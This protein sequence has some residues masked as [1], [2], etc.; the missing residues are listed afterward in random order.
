MLYQNGNPHGGDIYG[1][2]IRLDFSANIN[3]LGTPPGVMDAMREALLRSE[4]YPDPYCRKAVRAISRH[5]DIPEDCILLGNG[6]AELIYSFCYAVRPKRV[7][8]PAPTF[9]EY[10][11]A[12]RQTGSEVIRH[13]LR[14]DTQFTLDRTFLDS[15]EE[16]SPDTVFLCH[17]NNPTGQLIRQDVLTDILAFCK[18]RQ[19]RLFLD[20]CFLD[21]SGEPDHMKTQLADCPQQ[22]ILKALTKSYALAGIRIGYGLSSD[23]GLLR[24]MSETVQP[25]NVSVVAQ[26]AAV[27]AMGEDAYIAEAVNFIRT[28]REWLTEQLKTLGLAVC[29][30]DVNFILLRAPEGLEQALLKDGIAIRDCSNYPGLCGGWFRTAVRTHPEN[31]ILIRTIEKALREG[32]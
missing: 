23:S 2:E 27:A 26:A 3:P 19:I 28:E 11:A 12:L 18:N 9:A 25:W 30:S 6:A 17:P 32:L 21:L 20:E 5:E 24:R 8:L 14:P 31:L 22:F 16:I 13:P 15:M 4:H 7:L 10:E 29:P 1:K